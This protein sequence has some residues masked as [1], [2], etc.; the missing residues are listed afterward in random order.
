[1]AQVAANLERGSE[2][3]QRYV[4]TQKI[5]TRLLRTNSR[6]A[7]EEHRVLTVTPSEKGTGKKLIHFEGQYSEKD[8]LLSYSSPGFR[9][10]DLD[11][12][13]ELIESL[14]DDFVSDSASRDGINMHLFP[15]LAKDLPSYRFTLTG[16][17]QFQ[18]RPAYRV[19]FE[20][21]PDAAESRPWAGEMLVDREDLHPLS[22]QTKLTFKMPFLV[23]SILGT[24]LRQTGFSISYTRLAPGIWFPA[25][26]GTEMRLDV[27]FG[28]KRVIT[29]SM[30]SSDFQQVSADSAITFHP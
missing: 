30:E 15:F 18:N 6:L 1:M 9:T 14:S 12:D 7:R 3:R 27:L 21:L 28:Y 29:M 10:K 4:Y 26:Y 25:T 5:R 23:K 8:K 16:E 24:N 22:I 19:L 13:G 20:P 2:L 11:L 17:T